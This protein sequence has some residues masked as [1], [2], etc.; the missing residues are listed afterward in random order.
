[1][2]GFLPYKHSA[3]LIPPFTADSPFSNPWMPAPPSVENSDSSP[4]TAQFSKILYELISLPNCALLP[5]LEQLEG[6]PYF[7]LLEP[8]HF[9]KLVFCLEV[10]NLVRLAFRVLNDSLSEIPG[11]VGAVFSSVVPI[12]TGFLESDCAETGAALGLVRTALGA[13]ETIRNRL[14]ESRCFA[15]LSERMWTNDLLLESAEILKLMTSIS[16]FP[17]GFAARMFPLL[18]SLCEADESKV[19]ILAL[20]GITNLQINGCCS[21]E[22]FFLDSALIEDL[23]AFLGREGLSAPTVR[24]LSELCPYGDPLLALMRRHH[25]VF[26]VRRLLGGRD[27][28]TV[29]A[30]IVFFQNWLRS[31][32]DPDY[33]F[34]QITSVDFVSVCETSTFAAKSNMVELVFAICETAWHLHIT[35]LLSPRFVETVIDQIGCLPANISRRALSAIEIACKKCQ[36]EPGII[37]GIHSALEGVVPDDEWQSELS[38]LAFQ[39]HALLPGE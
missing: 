19:V 5:V 30:A 22:S 1:M 29:E 15:I 31:T 38:Q 35:R 26:E 6:S 32:A 13:G 37:A 20:D 21:L 14:F 24:L 33:L 4:D 25:T 28:A 11:A 23:T 27:P 9:E 10:P 34:D 18:W 36:T 17:V 12:I 39:V 8:V 16:G 3:P 2:A 7:S